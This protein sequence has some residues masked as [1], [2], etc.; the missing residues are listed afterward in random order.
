MLVPQKDGKVL[1]GIA[2]P[3]SATRLGDL[4]QRNKSNRH[5][6]KRWKRVTK[7]IHHQSGNPRLVTSKWLRRK[8]GHARHNGDYKR[9]QKKI[10]KDP[11]RFPAHP[12]HAQD[13]QGITLRVI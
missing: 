3:Q 5:G 10:R 4:G 6:C 13:L 12:A 9:S 7:K 8:E 2:A 1:F 11:I